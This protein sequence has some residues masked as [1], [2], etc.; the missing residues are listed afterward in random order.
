MAEAIVAGHL[1]V[2]ERT[3][4]LTAGGV[5]AA[6]PVA[7][8]PLHRP[9]PVGEK[10]SCDG[11]Q[12]AAGPDGAGATHPGGD[13]DRRAGPCGVGH[14]GTELSDEHVPLQL[15]AVPDRPKPLLE[16]G[17]PFLGTGEIGPGFTLP[18][19]AVWRPAFLLFGALRS[20]LS[21]FGDGTARS[22]EWANRIDLFG[23]LALTGTERLVLGLR[24]A[25][26]T[27]A[28]GRRRFSGYAADGGD[29]RGFSPQFNLDWD[30]VTHLF[31]EG[32]FGE[33]FPNLDPDDR[34]GLDFGLSV[35]RQPITFQDG[36]LVNDFIDAVGVTRNSLRPGGTANLRFTGLY[37]WNQINRHAPP[38]RGDI[39]SVPDRRFGNREA[40]R[41]RL[42]GGF[43]EIDWR[44]TTAAFDA[45]YVRGGALDDAPAG[46]RARDGLYAGVSFAGRPGSG[47]FNAALRLLTSVP[48]GQRRSRHA[49]PASAMSRDGGRWCS[50]SCRGRLTTPTTT[51]T[52]T[53]FVPTATT[54]RRRST[55]PSR[56][57]WRA[58]ASCSPARAWG[59]RAGRCRPS[60]RTSSER[61]SVIRSSPPTSA[62]SC[63]WKVRRATRRRRARARSRSASPMRSR[64]APASR[65]RS[66]GGTSSCSMPSRPGPPPERRGR[67]GGRHRAA[68]FR[69]ARRDA[70][71]VL[72]DGRGGTA[73]SSD[74]GEAPA[75]RGPDPARRRPALGAVVSGAARG[76]AGA[77]IGAVRRP[78]ERRVPR[79]AGARGRED[80]A[81]RALS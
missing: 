36:L 59:V 40:D 21:T 46:V 20:G 63:C 37:G 42:V 7:R 27:D 28:A 71:A 41:T 52:P 69:R 77:G 50:R 26:Q 32:D 14:A 16:L 51:S 38:V 1:V 15:D 17:P 12:P 31:F 72:A 61:R 39:A 53:P 49:L 34:R 25:D 56:D 4:N 74:A 54:A 33:L 62:A 76:R 67:T 22:S 19:G 2:R 57:R 13:H 58:P 70:G 24:P 6:Q 47:A 44:S 18:G 55:R 9:A 68:G 5:E 11:G 64:G 43:T 79:L 78:P 8:A 10:E 23:N 3:V 48:V 73:R 29:A 35:G 30:T 80:G 45:I 81:A 65:W 75:G 60:R 66:G